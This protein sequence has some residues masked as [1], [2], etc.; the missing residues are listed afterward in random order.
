MDG[1]LASLLPRKHLLPV[2]GISASI[3]AIAYIVLQLSHGNRNDII[4]SPLTQVCSLPADQQKRLPYPPDA[5]PGSR[6]VNSPY[7]SIRVYEWGPEDGRRVLLV[8][9]ISTP[10]IALASVAEGLVENGCRVILF[11]RSHCDA[12]HPV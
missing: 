11:G 4:E 6:D 2:L 10:G 7:G 8:H 1:W 9:G 3:A 5:L 12:F